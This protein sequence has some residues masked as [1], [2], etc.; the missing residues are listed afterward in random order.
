[1]NKKLLLLVGCGLLVSSC[2]APGVIGARNCVPAVDPPPCL[3]D[4]AGSD[5]T[6]NLNS[7]RANPPIVC[8]APGDTI[9]VNIVPTS[10]AEVGNVAVVPKNFA[11]TWLTGTNSDDPTMFEIKVPGWVPK[12]TDHDYGFVTNEGSCADPR[13]HVR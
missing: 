9:T 3:P 4:Q 10:K 2:A 7:M 11:D 6:L 13:V 8:V 1:M 5:V 12:N